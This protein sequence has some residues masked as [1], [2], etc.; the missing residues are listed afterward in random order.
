MTDKNIIRV[1]I[2]QIEY[3]LKRIEKYKRLDFDDYSS[4]QDA[5][6]ITLHNLYIILQQIIDIGS[7][8]IADDNLGDIVF[9]SDI[10]D[11][12][13]KEA[14]IEK[15]DSKELK[16]MIGFRNILAHEYG[17]LDLKIVY[18]VYT[19]RI[20]SIYRIIKSII[21]YTGV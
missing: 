4:D 6:D 10:A 18:D 13:M 19:N 16:L 1:K 17:N 14:I 15:E 11:I 5:I 12:L 3:S 21:L 2:S 8:I 9:L 7:H 20:N